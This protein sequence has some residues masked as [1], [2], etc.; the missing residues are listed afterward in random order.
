MRRLRSLRDCIEELRA[1]VEPQDID[2]EV[3]W[4]LPNT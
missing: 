3:D 4:N 2:L 1:F